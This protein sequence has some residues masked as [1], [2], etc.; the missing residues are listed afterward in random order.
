MIFAISS[1]LVLL[2]NIGL[3]VVFTGIILYVLPNVD[4]FV[5]L[6]KPIRNVSSEYGVIQLSLNILVGI[7]VFLA[8]YQLFVLVK[9]LRK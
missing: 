3:L 1:V 4:K 7:F 8:I 2:V 6:I 5:K 9:L